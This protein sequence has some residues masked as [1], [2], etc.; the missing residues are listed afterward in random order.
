MEVRIRKHA[1]PYIVHYGIDINTLKFQF[2]NRVQCTPL[3]K[4]LG[5]RVLINIARD[6]QQKRQQYEYFLAGMILV[7]EYNMPT[8]AVASKF[9]VELANLMSDL[10]SERANRPAWQH[11]WERFQLVGSSEQVC[12]I[13][14][15]T[16]NH[17]RSPCMR[18]SKL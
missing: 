1:V 4:V 8:W 16:V 7:P 6:M 10:Q 11:L 3:L 2:L 13:P 9:K 5:Y 14:L 15:L 12:C 18:N 17:N